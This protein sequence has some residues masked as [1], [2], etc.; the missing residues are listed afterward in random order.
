MSL[1]WSRSRSR[2]AEMTTGKL[3]YDSGYIT[4][5]PETGFHR[6]SSYTLQTSVRRACSCDYQALVR[7]LLKRQP[8]NCRMILYTREG[9]RKATMIDREKK[10]EETAFVATIY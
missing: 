10:P 1:W 4:W 2:S 5:K 9:Q 8:A 3:T 6:D 7:D